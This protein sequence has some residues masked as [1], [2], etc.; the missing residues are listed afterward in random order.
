[1]V[2]TFRAGLVISGW[3]KGYGFD[4]WGKARWGLLHLMAISVQVAVALH[5]LSYGLAL[6]WLTKKGNH[7]N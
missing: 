1:M 7:G 2:L 4:P 6:S 3:G 5:A